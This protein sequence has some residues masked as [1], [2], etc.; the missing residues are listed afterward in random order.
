MLMPPSAIAG[1]V[2]SRPGDDVKMRASRKDDD[3]GE[4]DDKSGHDMIAGVIDTCPEDALEDQHDSS[5]SKEHAEIVNLLKDL[6]CGF[7]RFTKDVSGFRDVQMAYT[8][9]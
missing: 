4:A 2:N 5:T 7:S 3:E 8:H 9:G 6:T 1:A